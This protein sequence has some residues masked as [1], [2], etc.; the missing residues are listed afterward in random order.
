MLNVNEDNKMER[1]MIPLFFM[2]MSPILFIIATI[3][4]IWS[5]E[6]CEVFG[7]AGAISFAL[8][9]LTAP[10]MMIGD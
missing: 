8:A 5:P 2:V 10:I 1:E 3:L 4:K 7:I 9:F 6:I